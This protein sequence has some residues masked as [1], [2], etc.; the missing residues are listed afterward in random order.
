MPVQSKLQKMKARRAKLTEKGGAGAMFYIGKPGTYRMRSVPVEDDMENGIEVIQFYL[1]AEIKGVISPASLGLPCALEAHYQS[2]R[3][4]GDED[5]KVTAGQM[6]RRIRYVMPHYRYKD[7]KGKEI[8]EEAGVKLLL[9]TNGQYQ[10]W[11]DYYLEE[12]IGDPSDPTNGF[13]IK[14]KREGSGKMD[15]EYSLLNCQPTKCHKAFA[16]KVNPEEMLKKALP[17]Y[18]ETKAYLNQFLGAAQDD[19]E[20]EDDLQEKAP[21][22]KPLT[23]SSKLAAAKKG[24]APSSGKK[25]LKKK[26]R[27]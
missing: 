15:T 18:D 8:D 6:S 11:I 17:T 12:E 13:D 20:D 24:E 14:Y 2:L 10:A 19:D 5:D 3:E 4:S 25:V 21:K 27:R 9:M 7:E 23:K 22:K 1:G 16:K 26:P